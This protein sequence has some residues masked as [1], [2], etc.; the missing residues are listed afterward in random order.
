[1]HLR[2][3]ARAEMIYAAY[4]HF[5]VNF[6]DCTTYGLSPFVR[7]YRTRSQFSQ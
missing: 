5:N 3:I 2:F 1:M 6:V 7:I 4:T